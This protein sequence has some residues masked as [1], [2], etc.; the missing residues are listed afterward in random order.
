MATLLRRFYL[1]TILFA[2]RYFKGKKTTN[3][4]NLIAWISI[5]AI[6][7]GA[8]A[9]ILVLSVFNGFEDLVK[10][11]YADF[12]TDIRVAPAQGKFL[13]LTTQ[14]LKQLKGVG[15]IRQLSTIA[16]EKAVLVNDEY[17]SI[18]YLKGVD[19]AYTGVS[20]LANHVFNGKY[21][22]GTI[23]A[24]K[25]FLG[26]GI[27][28]AVGVDAGLNISPLTVYLPNLKAKTFSGLDALNS[29]NVNV[30]GSFRLQQEFDNKFAVTNIA[31][32]KY[33]LDLGD[34]EYSAVEIALL[35]V[36]E[37]DVVVKR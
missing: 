5:L 20:G 15:G 7:V 12:Y 25:L 18:I 10:S 17:Q 28:N 37:T 22:P 32:V 4:I 34:D 3:A 24:P 21:D 30:S 2:W 6:A 11:L 14:Q 33:M 36:A 9:L 19:S 1:M 31:F 26:A 35:N 8:A 23:D 16:E 13:T 27:E 29:Y